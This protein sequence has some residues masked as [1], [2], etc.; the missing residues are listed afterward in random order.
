MPYDCARCICASLS[1][2]LF[3]SQ[4]SIFHSERYNI[5]SNSEIDPMT[6]CSYVSRLSCQPFLSLPLSF[7]LRV[8]N[9]ACSRVVFEATTLQ[10]VVF[11]FV[12]P[13][14]SSFSSSQSP[15]AFYWQNRRVAKSNENL[16]HILKSITFSSFVSLDIGS[17]KI[18]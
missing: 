17:S 15:V 18:C 9:T 13:Y 10:R 6:Y 1:F 4:P 14:F 5:A 2:S 16:F 3:L 8:R 11:F 7:P 12:F